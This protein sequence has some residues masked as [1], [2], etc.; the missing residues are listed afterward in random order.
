MCCEF[1]EKDKIQPAK[2]LPEGWT[3]YYTDPEKLSWRTSSEHT[4]LAGLVL[5]SPTGRQFSSVESAAVE[6]DSHLEVPSM[7]REFYGHVGCHAIVEVPD[8]VLVGR[9]FRQK[10]IDL[11]GRTKM[12]YGTVRDVSEDLLSGGLRTCTV[13]FSQKSRSLVNA[14]FTPN[15][16]SIPSKQKVPQTLAFGGCLDCDPRA[17]NYANVPYHFSWQV[18]DVRHEDFVIDEHGMFSPRLTMHFR[19]FHL[20]LTART[21]TIPNAGKGVFVS[22]TTLT[23][24]SDDLFVLDAGVLLDLG[25]YAPFRRADR[26]TAHV[27]LM[28]N[29]LHSSQCEEWNFD[30]VLTDDLFDITDDSTG[31]LHEI[32]CR[33]IPCYVNET[34]GHSAASVFA[35]HDPEGCVHY[36]LGHGNEG[37]GP[38]TLQA[39]GVEREIF[40]DYGA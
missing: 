4:G 33:H 1:I 18:P 29:F 21:S 40:I 19:G 37:D 32:A 15:G 25:V 12:V 22:C 20:T 11:E 9:A 24:S 13:E 31:K 2:G 38:F 30:T 39:N 34:D 5:M 14:G 28:K 3:F 27:F 8:H 6:L 36:L 16:A 10:W 26:K 17:I 23:G 35:Q 7:A